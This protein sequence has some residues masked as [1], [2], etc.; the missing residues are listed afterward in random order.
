MS[1]KFCECFH[2]VFVRQLSIIINFSIWR[3]I[4]NGCVPPE[5][6]SKGFEVTYAL[7]WSFVL[8]DIFIMERSGSTG[9][10]YSHQQ[11]MVCS[12]HPT[13][14]C[15]LIGY[16]K[17]CRANCLLCVECIND[18]NYK[19]HKKEAIN[20]KSINLQKIESAFEELRAKNSKEIAR[21]R[22]CIDNYFQRVE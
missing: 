14:T 3:S 1:A 7:I 17:E 19:V 13:K 11:S 9:D 6:P 12:E 15:S 8:T 2:I 5:E 4:W 16:D 21:N 18:A 22:H 20:H 10:V